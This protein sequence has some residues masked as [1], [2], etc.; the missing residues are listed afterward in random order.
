VSGRS[1]PAELLRAPPNQIT[2]YGICNGFLMPRIAATEHALRLGRS[3]PDAAAVSTM[4][5]A[6]AVGPSEAKPRRGLQSLARWHVL[7][8]LRPIV[9][10]DMLDQLEH[11]GFHL[12]RARRV[13]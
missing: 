8:L 9:L 5:Q 1:G 6:A 10:V 4:T 7:G 12:G 3:L 11:Q 13:R 2:D